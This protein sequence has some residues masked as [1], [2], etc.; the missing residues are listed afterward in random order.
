MAAID[1]PSVQAMRA[2]L[3]EVLNAAR[4]LKGSPSIEPPLTAS[5]LGSSIRDLT[6]SFL[7][8]AHT[9]APKDP[10]RHAHYAIIETAAREIFIDLLA[11]AAI[12]DPAFVQMWNLLDTI[13]I[14]SD[15]EQCEPGL[16]FWLIEELLD[17]QTID[18]C[19]QVFDYLESRRE[20]LTSKHFNDKK[21]IIL[22]CC[23]ELLRR[24]SR[25]E[26][27]V[28]CGRVFIFLFQSFPLGDKSSVN[29]RG[30]FHVENVTAFDQ[31]P[32]DSAMVEGPSTENPQVPAGGDSMAVDASDAPQ[33]DSDEVHLPS[34]DAASKFGKTVSFE[35]KSKEEGHPTD[36]HILYPIFWSLQETFSNPIK[37]FDAANFGNF[38]MALEKTVHAFVQRQ[39][40]ADGR[41]TSRNPDEPKSSHKRKREIDEND[42]I[43]GFNPKYLTSRD[44]FDLEISDLA[45]RRHVLVQALILVDFLLSLTAKA[46][47]KLAGL[48]AQNKS[49]LYQHTLSDEDAKWALETRATIASYLQ[50]G[51][52]GKF[53]YRMVD[54]ILSRDKN[55][56][57]WKAESCPQIERP[58]SSI[59]SMLEAR[60]SAQKASAPRR[61]RSTPLGSLDLNFLSEAQS[62][63][64]LDK[65]K[66][67]ERFDIPDPQSFERAVANDDFDMEMAKSEE[68]KQLAANAKASK[69]WR[70]LRVASKNRLNLF[71][72]LDDNAQK[73]DVL[74]KADEDGVKFDEEVLADGTGTGIRVEHE[75]T[76]SSGN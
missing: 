31:P 32:Y 40:D 41:G 19:A 10:L 69:A 33:K 21:F 17:S 25:A 22:R 51:P 43:V 75:D 72:K 46:K 26:N 27:T 38:K 16:I 48:S 65:L 53:Y 15:N 39:K 74:F 59:Q 36:T 8:Q 42:L 56:V 44:L 7:Q 64:G 14:L 37:L 34:S 2:A 5:E 24:L 68:D 71:D 62:L 35:E 45:F 60:S 9:Q 3:H 11:T 29:L 12:D 20:R 73:L 49:V 30:E 61:L 55:W 70:A 6:P 18:G 1:I 76:G 66:D 28:F 52:E 50:Q 47:A 4:T 63:S 67:A 13:S 23:N 57:A 58:P 54:T